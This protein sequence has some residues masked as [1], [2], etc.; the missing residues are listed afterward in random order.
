MRNLYPLQYVSL[1]HPIPL[2]DFRE[3]P[4]E[5]FKRLIAFNVDD[6]ILN[7]PVGM[8]NSSVGMLE[9]DAVLEEKEVRGG[10]DQKSE[11]SLGWW[12]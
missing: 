4:T 2:S 8:L 5:A 6:E 9:E 11:F 10:S 7:S 12:G 3:S 1:I